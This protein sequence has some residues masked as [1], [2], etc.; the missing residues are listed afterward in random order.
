VINQHYDNRSLRRCL[1]CDSWRKSDFGD[2]HV[3]GIGILWAFVAAVSSKLV[4]ERIEGKDARNETAGQSS[5]MP[6]STNRTAANA[7]ESC[8]YDALIVIIKTLRDEEAA[9]KDSR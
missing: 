4:A 9:T 8:N 3:A 2:S 1:S 6:A 5:G 7:N